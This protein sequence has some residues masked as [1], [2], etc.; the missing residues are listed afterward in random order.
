MVSILGALGCCCR[1][2]ISTLGCFWLLLPPCLPSLSPFVISTLGCSWLPLPPCLPSLS[3]FVI[4]TLGCSWLPLPPCLPSLSPFVT[5]TL[6]C[7]WLPLP[8][9]LPSLSPFMISILGCRCR[10]VSLHLSLFMISILGCSWLPLPPC[11]PSLS[12]FVT[13]TLGCS[14]LPLP[15]CLP[16]LSPFVISAPLWAALGCRCRLVSPAWPPS[17][18]PF[19]AGLGCRCRLVSQASRPSIHKSKER[20]F[21][22]VLCSRF[23]L[24]CFVGCSW[25]LPQAGLFSW[26]PA[27]GCRLSPN[28]VSLTVSLLGLWAVSQ[29]WLPLPPCLPS[30]S[31]FMIPFWAALGCRRRLLFQACLPSWF[32]FGL[33]LAAAAALS[34]SLFPFLIF[35][36]LF[37]AATTA[38]LS[39]SLFFFMIAL[40]EEPRASEHLW[41]CNK[42]R[43]LYE[44][45]KKAHFASL[46]MLSG[47]CAGVIP[48]SAQRHFHPGLCS[49][50]GGATL[51]CCH[52]ASLLGARPSERARWT[53][54]QHGNALRFLTNFWIS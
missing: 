44:H 52:L 11:L 19:W 24:Y 40:P 50:A 46:E 43:P 7:S 21:Q 38:A 35:L 26:F 16:S 28:I 3:A 41:I 42:K 36:K 49:A 23:L 14:W 33:L 32:P 45:C 39:P 8:P 9:C 37:L 53:A 12:P 4:S 1:L 2:V 30:L 51:R 18:F 20:R 29:A 25:L 5:S 31:P 27:L 34:P 6:G 47:V 13:S 48:F 54:R 10:L 17:W 22:W 15:P